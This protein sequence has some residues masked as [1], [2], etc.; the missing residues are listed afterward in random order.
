MGERLCPGL[1]A[2][3]LNAWLAAVG[4]VYL[5]PG[6]RLRWSDDPVP[7]AVLVAWGDEDP[8]RLV[9][10][11]WPDDDWVTDLPI[12]RHRP[13]HLELSLNPEV[14]AWADRAAWAR[15]DPD[16]WMLS[17]LHTDLAW[18]PRTKTHVVER[19]Q[20]HTP[21]P[22]RDNTIHD[23]VRK[24][25][26]KTDS[27]AISASLAGSG[28]RVANYGLGFDASRIVSLA[29][30]A[31]QMVDPV[32]EILAFFGMA[33]FP[34]RGDGRRRRQRGWPQDATAGAGFRWVT[35][36]APLDREA[37]DALADLGLG[38][39][40]FRSGVTSS[41]EV[42][43]YEARGPSDVTRGFGSRRLAGPWDRT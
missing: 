36:R 8:V 26:A 3:W 23:R 39:A 5:A 11:A 32:I 7:L 42:V 37:I 17:S 15:T 40:A 6:L 1:P 43:R 25:L 10:D 18:D 24:L 22:G 2:D 21:M 16:G 28:R 27:D 13:G 20:L 30:D 12:A 35:W 34:T 38:G 33:L 14:G 19:G 4:A 31:S 41:W 9:A 29:D